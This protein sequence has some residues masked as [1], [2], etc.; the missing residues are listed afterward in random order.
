MAEI[1]KA[2]K[3]PPEYCTRFCGTE[4]GTIYK[5]DSTEGKAIINGSHKAETLQQIMDKF[6]QL[7]VICPKCSLPEVDLMVKKKRIFGRCNACGQ[8]VEFDSTHKIA[9]YVIKNPPKCESTVKSKTKSTRPRYDE[10][11][12]KLTT[13]HEKSAKKK[14]SKSKGDGAA[15]LKKIP[16]EGD[17][18]DEL[19][20]SIRASIDPSSDGDPIVEACMGVQEA[21]GLDGACIL[22]AALCLKFE[23]EFD[24]CKL[25]DQIPNLKP[26][27]VDLK[28]AK[29]LGA[30]ESFVV[31]QHPDTVPRY[32]LVLKTLYEEDVLDEDDVLE[33]YE[34]DTRK[35]RAY[36]PAKNA[37]AP[38]LKWLGEAE[39]EDSSDDS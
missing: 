6:I 17:E 23:D 15:K 13:K 31:I 19:I 5:F 2:L 18:M 39:S 8:N 34:T 9:A 1:A 36:A 32:P 12:P 4:L 7:Y 25:G 16:L 11:T 10:N 38:F 33:Y 22:Y 35:G 26:V 28:A 30:V 27:V 14:S 37:A 21:R 24:V 3:R 20:S 29:I